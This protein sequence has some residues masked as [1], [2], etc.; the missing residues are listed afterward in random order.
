MGY[1]SAAEWYGVYIW[2]YINVLAT[3]SQKPNG[4]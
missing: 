3:A 4:K 2:E 1:D